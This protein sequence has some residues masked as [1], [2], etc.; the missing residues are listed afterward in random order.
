MNSLTLGSIVED[1]E[2]V[3][4]DCDAIEHGQSPETRYQRSWPAD[5]EAPDQYEKSS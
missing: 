1:R 4:D 3:D 5:D 2:D